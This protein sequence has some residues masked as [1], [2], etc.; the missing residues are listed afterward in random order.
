MSLG[1]ASLINPSW[2]GNFFS[3][4]GDNKALLGLLD[5]VEIVV[6]TSYAISV[7]IAVFLHMILPESRE[8]PQGIVMNGSDLPLH[9]SPQGSSSD[10][11]VQSFKTST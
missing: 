5:A 1:L 7:L 11:I 9:N 6:E 8:R 4:S 2:F 10:E 3:Y